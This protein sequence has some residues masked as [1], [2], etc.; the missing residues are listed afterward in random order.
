MSAK[1]TLIQSNF[2]FLP[3][4][5]IRRR[6]VTVCP[7]HRKEILLEV[8]LLFQDKEV[9][10]TPGNKQTIRT[11]QDVALEANELV[12]ITAEFDQELQFALEFFFYMYDVKVAFFDP[13]GQKYIV[14]NGAPRKAGGRERGVLQEFFPVQ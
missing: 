7:S 11:M 8:P 5:Q 2:R 4:P 12:C 14:L 13:D 1:E 3:L 10:F 6:T 9:P